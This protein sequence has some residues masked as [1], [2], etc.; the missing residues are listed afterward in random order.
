[1]IKQVTYLPYT[2]YTITKERFYPFTQY[3]D[4]NPNWVKTEPNS[5]SYRSQT[6]RLW[7]CALP[8][9][10]DV[11]F[12]L[13]KCLTGQPLKT[14]LGYVAVQPTTSMVQ[15]SLFVL[16]CNPVILTVSLLGMANLFLRLSSSFACTVK[17]WNAIFRCLERM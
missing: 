12:S 6:C 10:L 9:A 13:A 17:N 15:L 2:V 14:T 16:Y 11:A 5:V 4:S 8:H 1:M 7:L 3:C